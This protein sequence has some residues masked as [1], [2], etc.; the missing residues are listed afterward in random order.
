[1]KTVAVLMSSYNGQEYIG[2]QIDSILAQEGVN[3]DLIIRDDGSTDE[4]RK[5]LRG[6][7]NRYDNIQ[8]IEGKQFGIGRSFMSLLYGNYEAD[9]YAFS[10]QDDIWH[11]NKLR[12]AVDILEREKETSKY[13][14]YVGNQNCVSKE[15]VF[16]QKR[17]PD[18]YPESNICQSVF[19]NYYAGCTMVMNTELKEL[20]SS[21]D[22]RPPM[23]FF[24]LRIHD[25]WV[26]CV[27]HAAGKV[28]YDCNAYMDFRRHDNTSSDEYVPNAK[29]NKLKRYVNKIKRLSRKGVKKNNISQT[30]ANV[31]RYYSDFLGEDEKNVI[32]K[33]E[34]YNDGIVSKIRFLR[35]GIIK[36]YSPSDHMIVNLKVILGVL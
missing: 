14:L 9:Y 5:I 1:M 22:R 24:D 4:T 25:A 12:S 15:G 26:A 31:L 18:N 19:A 2:T 3:V 10:D 33:I 13:L 7:E 8:V 34:N 21:P 20:L 17:F 28:I 6:Y 32:Y 35:S 36:K 27:S 30:A 16:L 11:K 23:D 29:T